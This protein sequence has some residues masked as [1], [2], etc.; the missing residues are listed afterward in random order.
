MKN[1][2]KIKVTKHFL[3]ILVGIIVFTFSLV[4]WDSEEE[5]E[6]EGENK[7]DNLRLLIVTVQKTHSIKKNVMIKTY[8]RILPKWT[9]HIRAK[10][11]G[12]LQSVLDNFEQGAYVKKD[13]VLA[14]LDNIKFQTS[15]ADAKHQ[16]AIAQLL[17]QTEKQN[18]TLAKKQWAK[19][20]KIKK[21]TDFLLRTPQIK[22]AQAQLNLAEIKLKEVKL[23]KNYS[24]IIAPYNGVITERLI[25]YGDTI[26]TGQKI[27]TIISSNHLIIKIELSVQQWKLLAA[28]WQGQ[29]VNLYPTEDISNSKSNK[30][31]W[32][33]IIE[34]GGDT[35]DEKTNLH[36][37]Y[38]RVNSISKPK[39]GQFVVIEITGKEVASLLKAPSSAI[40]QDGKVWF[41]DNN[42]LLRKYTALEIYAE[43][44]YVYIQIPNGLINTKNMNVVV[45]P[46]TSYIQGKKVEPKF[47]KTTHI[48]Q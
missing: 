19:H 16:I 34:R 17:L 45:Y 20:K 21:P 2:K 10:G 14:E 39:P 42:N 46:Y 48:T 44:Q 36:T 9:T 29:Q 28:D 12:E 27:G 13:S 18:G 25:N 41:V 15:L 37:L 32:T 5:K 47:I 35:I 4:V 40:T 7:K 33:A 43:G 22:A 1:N 23:M 31:K 3:A 30:E 6:I 8:G 24:K 38:L 26:Q 11:Q